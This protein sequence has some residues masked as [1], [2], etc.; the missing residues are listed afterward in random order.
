M[1]ARASITLLL[2][3]LAALATASDGPQ[4]VFE[5]RLKKFHNARAHDINGNCC[6]GGVPRGGQCAGQCRTKFRVCLKHFQNQIDLAQGCTFGE[7][8]TPVLGANNLTITRAPIR[9]DIN[10]KWPVRQLYKLITPLLLS[11]SIYRCP[12]TIAVSLEADLAGRELHPVS[13]ESS[14]L[15]SHR[16]RRRSLSVI[17]QVHR[18]KD[19]NRSRRSQ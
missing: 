4:G 11:P 19:P 3:Q 2:L 9:F 6:A 12:K 10:F 7:E 14:P 15:S 16:I 17:R 1:A 18:D 13:I 8:V 5:I